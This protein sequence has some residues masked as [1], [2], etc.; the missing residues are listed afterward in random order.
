VHGNA[1]VLYG[2]LQLGRAPLQHYPGTL[3]G[4]LANASKLRGLLLRRH[5]GKF[6][7]RALPVLQGRQFG[8]HHGALG[9]AEVATG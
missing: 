3:N 2:L 6:A 8:C 4:A 5:V 9:G 7:Y 1:T